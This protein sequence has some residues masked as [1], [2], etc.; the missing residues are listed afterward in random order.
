MIIVGWYLT[1][2]ED[3]DHYLLAMAL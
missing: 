2:K 1:I 3:S